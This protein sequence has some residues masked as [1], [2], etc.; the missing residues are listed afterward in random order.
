MSTSN[1]GIRCVADRDGA[2]LLDIKRDQFFSLNPVASLIWTQ[3]EMGA[4]MDQ[5][6]ISVAVETGTEP[7]V[8]SADVDEFVADLK[9]RGLLQLSV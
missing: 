6:K 2:V 4:T 9:A 7:T 5:I 1:S 8:V 3:L